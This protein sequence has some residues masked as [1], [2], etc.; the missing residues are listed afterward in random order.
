M[1]PLTRWHTVQLR[2]TDKE[3]EEE[4]VLV[5]PGEMTKVDRLYLYKRRTPPTPGR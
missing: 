1:P 2:S 5:K 3:S 4:Q